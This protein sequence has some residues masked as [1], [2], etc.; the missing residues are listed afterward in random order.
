MDG[1][2]VNWKFL[3]MMQDQQKD[4]F[5]KQL[6]VVGNCGLH[7][8]HNAFK[9][10]FSAWSLEKV[11]SSMYR[12]FKDAP[13]RREDY[14]TVNGLTTGADSNFPLKF[15]GHRWLENEPV[16]TRALE[17]WDRVIKY[18]EA[19]VAK[20][21]SHPNN[22]SF[23]VLLNARKDKLIKAKFQFF[24]AVSM[25]VTP[26]LT[27]YQ[28]DQPL[29]PFLVIDLKKLLKGL[30]RR[31]IKKEQLAIHDSAEK[32]VKIKVSDKDI[33]CITVMWMLA[34]LQMQP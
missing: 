33:T 13:A 16:L 23:D 2:N 4:Q 30:L 22:T 29:L 15:C 6:L 25:A 18:V 1:P 20:K 31:F 17:V 27:K 11:L 32:L 21:V 34:L 12:L 10:C 7:T 9:A 3:E 14:M 28:S 5:S 26:F 19:V 8:M 24:L